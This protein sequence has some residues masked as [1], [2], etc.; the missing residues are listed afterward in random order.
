MLYPLMQLKNLFS[1]Y[2][3][4]LL[5]TLVLFLLLAG[6][7]PIAA[8]QNKISQLH[9]TINTLE[10][11]DTF[12]V[13]QVNQ[14]SWE[15]SNTRPDSC[16]EYAN[17]ALHQAKALHYLKGMARAYNLLG[18]VAINDGRNQEAHRLND[19]ALPL[20]R[21]SGD[22]FVVSVVLNDL[23]IIYHAQKQLERSI[24]Y[25]LQSLDYVPQ[26]D[27]IG[28]V[29]TNGNIALLY[30]ELGYRDIGKKFLE[31]A[32][33]TSNIAADPYVMEVYKSIE[34]DYYQLGGEQQQALRS[35]QEAYDIAYRHQHYAK[36]VDYLC[37]EARQY[38][39]MGRQERALNVLHQALELKLPQQLPDAGKWIEMNIMEVL[40]S[41]DRNEEV[42]Q[43][44]ESQLMRI[45]SAE[46]DLIDLAK[47]HELMAKAY[48]GTGD[49]KKAFQH[50]CELKIFQDSLY[51][52][53]ISK[54]V[55][56]M[57]VQHELEEK[58]AENL[59]LRELQQRDAERLKNHKQINVALGIII[60]LSIIIVALI[61][62][63]LFQKSARS[64]SLEKEVR[65][66][67]ADLL[68]RNE[69]LEGFTHIVSHDFKEPM[70]NI[71]SFVNLIERK[72][73]NLS[74][75]TRT[76]FSYVQKSARQLYSLV[77]DVLQFSKI[78]NTR[79]DHKP[80]NLQQVMEN[81]SL[82]LKLLINEKNATLQYS[83]L[84]IIDASQTH[85]FLIL[86]NLIEN[87]LVYNRSEHP[88]VKVTYRKKDDL[89]EICIEDNGLGIPQEYRDKV[90]KMFF[91]LYNREE[92]ASTGMGLAIVKKLVEGI[93]GKIHIEDGSETMNTSFC[94]EFP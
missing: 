13:D 77:D 83:E 20:A 19:L 27:T 67:T 35:I 38:L 70:R 72:E 89:H 61:T 91:R 36:A 68:A 24:D 60:L 80:V 5:T 82:N 92:F 10:K 31:A 18:V 48:S 12:W 7:Q 81:I 53:D 32:L 73:D 62:Y 3:S 93:N 29:Y 14:L 39:R 49:F 54:A 33:N 28:R 30:L 52:S 21:M 6:S 45:D 74:D 85:L 90:F 2:R 79:S 94:L 55:A 87:G 44:G 23:A 63:A 88:V 37:D 42:I 51:K 50:H 25:Y 43:L 78:S 58:D 76:Y 8:Q 11:K 16:T 47:Y 22:S 75:D 57:E 65:L 1:E 26:Y 40:L 34:S 15:F 17:Q 9:Q 84:P 64:S 46:L 4:I 66:K 59:A 41:R 69:E 56:E 86:K 71:V